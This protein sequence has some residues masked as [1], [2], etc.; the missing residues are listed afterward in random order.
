MYTHKKQYITTGAASA[1][2]RAALIMLHGRGAAAGDIVRL[3]SALNVDSLAIYAPQATNR[4]WYPYSFMAGD[5]QNQPALASAL[6]VLNELVSDVNK[7]GISSDRI[8]FLG[9]SQGACLTLE[10]I[11]RHPSRYAGVIAFTGGLIGKTLSPGKY[12]GDLMKTPV[13]I[14]T[15]VPDE[16]VPFS[17]VQETVKILENMN[18]DITLKVFEGRRHTII[19]DEITLANDVILSN[20]GV[21]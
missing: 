21:K 1:D 19:N 15:G 18:A 3:S 5:E 2:A 4:S 11:A 20:D 13:L 9:F 17:R 6:E 16:H 8:Y 12:A 7:E 10:Y 14:T